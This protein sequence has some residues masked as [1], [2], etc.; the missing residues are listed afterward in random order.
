MTFAKQTRVVI[1]IIII[2]YIPTN[3]LIIFLKATLFLFN[4]SVIILFQ[5]YR[6]GQFYGMR[7]AVPGENH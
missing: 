5:L 6:G 4:I 2:M 3:K 1:Y 7:T